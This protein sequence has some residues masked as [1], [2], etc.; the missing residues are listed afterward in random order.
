MIRA[1]AALAALALL[2]A[3]ASAATSQ[4]KAI[5]GPVEQE[6]GT[7]YFDVYKD[8]GAGIF[9]TTLDWS[10]V[11]VMEPDKAT[12]PLDTG[13]EWPDSIDTAIAEAKRTHIQVDLTVTNLPD[14]ASKTAPAKQYADFLTAAA[15]RY[16]AVH[17]WTIWDKPAQTFSPTRYAALLDASYASLKAKSKSNLVIGG[18]SADTNTKVPAHRW[19]P[20]LKLTNGKRPRLDLYGHDA[21]S[22]TGKLNLKSLKAEVKDT[23]G[24]K[25][26]FL[27][28]LTLPVAANSAFSF[29]FTPSSAAKLLTAAY[30]TT[31][32]DSGLYALGYDGVTDTD[33]PSGLIDPKGA[34]RPG[35]A[36]YKKA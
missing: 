8:L 2:P 33:Y 32:H 12:D 30:K 15:K 21:T 16:P 3:T 31:K 24:N 20:K 1:L 6:D 9:E 11:A 13:Y 34:R 28:R 35:Y 4:K 36:A 23:F 10:Q 29:H 27:T 14:W 25:K 7:S 22:K 17:L 26:I 19:I 18:N 5:W